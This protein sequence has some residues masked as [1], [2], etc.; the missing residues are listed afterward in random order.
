MKV[1]GLEINIVDRHFVANDGCKQRLDESPIQLPTDE[2][3]VGEHNL[4]MT[5]GSGNPYPRIRNLLYF[6]DIS[7]ELFFMTSEELPILCPVCKN[8]YIIRRD[9]YELLKK[10]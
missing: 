10:G 6:N 4:L 8:R 9:D 3:I 7:I 5:P 2:D 1:Q